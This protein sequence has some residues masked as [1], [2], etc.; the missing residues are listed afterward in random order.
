M[1]INARREFEK[2]FKELPKYIEEDIKNI[3][4][5]VEEM[6][7]NKYD[8]HYDNDSDTYVTIYVSAKE[9]IKSL[10]KNGTP[11]ISIEIIPNFSITIDNEA[12]P[13][14][15]KTIEEYPELFKD[16]NELEVVEEIHTIFDFLVTELVGEE[17]NIN[18]Y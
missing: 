3:Q 16:N 7:P 17:E 11:F 4:N 2:Y 13:A 6:F 15:Y 9:V 5:L 18:V 10:L 12:D 14:L 8:V 1:R